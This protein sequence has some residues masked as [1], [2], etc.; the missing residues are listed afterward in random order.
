MILHDQ[1]SMIVMHQ[2]QALTKLLF[3]VFIVIELCIL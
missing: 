3:G 2:L 1:T